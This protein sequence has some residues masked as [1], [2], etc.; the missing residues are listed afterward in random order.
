MCGRINVID[1]PLCRLVCEQLGIPFSTP[2]NNNLSP[3][4]VVSTVIGVETGYRQLDLNW[5]IK[6]VWSK[7]MIINAQSETVADKPTFRQAFKSHRCVIPCSGWYEWR[8]EAGTKKKYLFSHADK[9]PLYMAGIWYEGETPQLVTLT[10]SPNP[11]CAEYHARMPAL[12]L[13]EN[14]D[15]WFQSQP[16]QLQ[17]VLMPVS[18]EMINVQAAG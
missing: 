18:P 12:I 4:Q 17:P 11:K 7:R 16:E 3:G 5:G 15:Y 13:L 8:E 1:D 2:T 14:I 10:T 6:P 9:Q